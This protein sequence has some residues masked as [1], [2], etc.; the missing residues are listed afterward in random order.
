MMRIPWDKYEVAILIDSY[1]RISTSGAKW[2]EEVKRVSALLRS[3]AVADGRKIDE[4]FRNENGINL[5]LWEIKY[6][7]SGENGIR[8][9]SA[10]FQ[11]MVLLYN[12]K[13]RE[14]SKILREAKNVKPILYRVDDLLILTK[15]Y[16]SLV[17]YLMAVAIAYLLRKLHSPFPSNCEPWQPIRG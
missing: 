10:L 12:T 14:F 6:Q 8:S 11:E 7:F 15:L 16:F 4:S 17:H 1:V 3:R 2:S 5:R 9:T 13:P